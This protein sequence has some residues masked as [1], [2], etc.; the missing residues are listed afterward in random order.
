M[1][2]ERREDRQLQTAFYTGKLMALAG[3]WRINK[4]DAL[5]T[6]PEPNGIEDNAQH[7]E[8]RQRN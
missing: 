5:E 4:A 6:S 1:G 8:S 7:Y 2:V 3:A